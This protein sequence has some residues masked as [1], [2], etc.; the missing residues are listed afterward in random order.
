MSKEL[1]FAEM[2]NDSPASVVKPGSLVDAVIVNLLPSQDKVEFVVINA[3]LKSEAFI[4][5]SEF[6]L[7]K[8]QK[9]PYEIG[10][11]LK[12]YVE[13]LEDGNGNTVLSFEKAKKMEV[14][15]SLEAAMKDNLN[16][17][18]TVCEV[19]RGGF[20]VD[21][22]GITGFLPL[23]LVDIRPVKDASYLKGKEAEFKVIKL[24]KPNNIVVS[25]KAALLAENS[26]EREAILTQLQEGQEVIGVIK[27]ITDYGAF[28]DLG[29]IDG[30]LH[31]TDISW[32]R[33]KHPSEVVKIGDEVR[34]KV[35]KFDREKNRVSLGL[36]Q[37]TED[38]W[39]DLSRRFPVGSRFVGKVTNI[40]DYGCFVE[41][42]NGIE[43]LVHMSEMDW[44][45]K[46]IHPSRVVTLG[47][48]IEVQ[49]LEIDE[50]RRR[51]SLGIKQ[52]K[53]N[54][55]IAFAENHKKGDHIVGRIK[56]MTDF[57]MF[58]GLDGNIDGLIHSSDISWDDSSEN[59]LHNYKKGQE[60]EAVI[61]AIDAERERISLGIKQLSDDVYGAFYEMHPKGTK[62]SGKVTEVTP[63]V[64]TV[65]LTD[66]IEGKLR[67]QDISDL[68]NIKNANDIFTV[69]DEIEVTVI[70]YDK[71]SRSILLSTKEFISTNFDEDAGNTMLGDLLKEQIESKNIS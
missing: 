55:W 3:S 11:H 34:V 65:Q 40:T 51:I 67:A 23:S 52:C 25:R 69:D 28:V 41:I 61:L 35:L 14:W 15:L 19:V 13:A 7:A 45:N 8:D 46:N 43:G 27:N 24:E 37:L 64:V 38:P 59:V 20:I 32:K 31:I 53:A 1:S 33:I 5:V 70:G 6:N 71:K 54:P 26:V 56:S 50:Q 42:D 4:P 58:V 57:G 44:T 21:L 68:T 63:K 36:K 39:G 18:G 22:G 12:V 30:L 10:D 2:I 62:I 48:E 47:Q 60:V 29:G 17:T 16:V 66:E 9:F 49:V